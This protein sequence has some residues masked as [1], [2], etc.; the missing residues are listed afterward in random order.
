MNTARG[1]YSRVFALNNVG[2][3][4]VNTLASDP[5]LA[6]LP[7]EFAAEVAVSGGLTMFT[8]GVGANS[9]YLY[10]WNSFQGYDDAFWTHGTHSLKFGAAVER[11]QLNM[12]MLSDASGTFNFG[13]LSDFL[14]NKP[15]R[16][17]AAL[18]TPGGA[19]A[20]HSWVSISRTIGAPV[21]T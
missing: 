3:T 20:K 4:A 12:Y 17:T 14:Q 9:H 5:T 19:C 6:A 13:T 1:G 2:A 18:G 11:M 10:G 16:F 7:G 8:G 21:Q 15:K